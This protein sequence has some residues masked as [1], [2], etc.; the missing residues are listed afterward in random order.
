VAALERN[1]AFAAFLFGASL[2]KIES[3]ATADLVVFDY[4]PPT[5]MDD[6]G[7]HVLFGLPGAPVRH[8]LV[9]GELVVKDGASTKIDEE[10]VYAK[11]R[12]EAAKLWKRM[13]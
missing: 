13:R 2:G 8:V 5:P 3:G 1:R 7:G 12:E 10:A 6:F 11:A 4:R 9:G